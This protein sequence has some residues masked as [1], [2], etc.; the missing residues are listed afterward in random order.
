MSSFSRCVPSWIHLNHLKWSCHVNDIRF[1]HPMTDIR[2]LS[3]ARELIHSHLPSSLIRFS[4]EFNNG[5][6]QTINTKC[7]QTCRIGNSAVST[8][9]H[10]TFLPG[11]SSTHGRWAEIYHLS[12][13]TN[14]TLFFYS[15]FPSSIFVLPFY[16]F[17][18]SGRWKELDDRMREPLSPYRWKNKSWSCS[19]RL[20]ANDALVHA[21]RLW[22]DT[23]HNGMNMRVYALSTCGNSITIMK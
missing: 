8:Y 21:Y 10:A 7:M 9:T 11:Q 14:S 18:Y 16:A 20:C 5:V 6:K 15:I 23:N 4:V 17:I 13:L 3:S 19:Q 2:T 22:H 12:E 1:V